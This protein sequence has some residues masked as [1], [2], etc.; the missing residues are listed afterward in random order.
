M[1]HKG[2][3]AVQGQFLLAERVH[4]NPSKADKHHGDGTASVFILDMVGDYLIPLVGID[5]TIWYD[6]L[7]SAKKKEGGLGNKS[8]CKLTAFDLKRIIN[9]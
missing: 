4:W 7:L 5:F 6:W 1:L 3:W 8:P 9:K 2:T